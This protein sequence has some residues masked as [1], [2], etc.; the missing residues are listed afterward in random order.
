MRLNSGAQ[1]V[2]QGRSVT[3]RHYNM[4]YDDGW[5]PKQAK[6]AR[7]KWSEGLDKDQ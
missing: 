3:A 7:R 6:L 5:R 4:I 2:E 1:S